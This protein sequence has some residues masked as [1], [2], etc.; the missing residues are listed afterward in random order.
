ML[1]TAPHHR[2]GDESS[3]CGCV[4]T[5]IVCIVLELSVVAYAQQPQPSIMWSPTGAELLEPLHW[6][7]SVNFDG[8]VVSVGGCLDERCVGISPT[9]TLFDVTTQTVATLPGEPPLTNVGITGPYTS[10]AAPSTAGASRSL[11]IVRSCSLCFDVDGVLRPSRNASSPQTSTSAQDFFREVVEV[12][13]NSSAEK[14]S[15]SRYKVIHN[16]SQYIPAAS[17]RCNASCVS[18][19]S[20]IYIVGGL[21]V[22]SQQE[23]NLIAALEL[24]TGAFRSEVVVIPST[25]FE[26]RDIDTL[27][28]SFLCSFGKSAPVGVASNNIGI[29]FSVPCWDP[30]SGMGATLVTGAVVYP[31]LSSILADTVMILFPNVS[32]P[33]G[34]DPI[35]TTTAILPFASQFMCTG[36]AVEVGIDFVFNDHVD[37]DPVVGDAAAVGQ[38]QYVGMSATVVAAHASFLGEL[39]LSPT[40]ATWNLYSLGGLH[41]DGSLSSDIQIGPTTFGISAPLEVVVS[42]AWSPSQGLH[43]NKTYGQGSFGDVRFQ[44]GSNL[45]IRM[46]SLSNA[47]LLMVSPFSDCA[48]PLD[49]TSIMTL[50]STFEVTIPITAPHANELFVCVSDGTHVLAGTVNATGM[51][52]LVKFFSAVN[53]LAPFEVLPIPPPTTLPPPTT[54][55]T[56][57]VPTT[58]TTAAPLPAPTTTTVAPQ[59]PPSP[60][61]ELPSWLPLYAV[62]IGGI[63]IVVIVIGTGITCVYCCRRYS[64]NERKQISQ[65]DLIALENIANSNKYT[66][67]RRLGS[68]GNGEVFLVKRKKDGEM[69]AIKHVRCV[70]SKTRDDLF[71][72]SDMLDR[73]KGHPNMVEIL[74]MSLHEVYIAEEDLDDD[75][76]G[77][78][79]DDEDVGTYNISEK[80]DLLTSGDHRGVVARGAARTS[81]RRKRAGSNGF[82]GYDTPSASDQGT[83]I[84][85]RIHDD[86]DAQYPHTAGGTTGGSD[87]DGANFLQV[88]RRKLRNRKKSRD[89]LNPGDDITVS[90]ASRPFLED[91]SDEPSKGGS[92]PSSD[93]YGKR[94]VI[95]SDDNTGGPPYA[96]NA[97]RPHTNSELSAS[98]YYLSTAGDGQTPH[99]T[100]ASGN[101]MRKVRFQCIVMKYFKKGDLA[102]FM[103]QQVPVFSSERPRNGSIFSSILRPKGGRTT[104]RDEIAS[105]LGSRAPSKAGADTTTTGG[106]G[107]YESDHTVASHAGLAAPDSCRTPTQVSDERLEAPPQPSGYSSDPDDRSSRGASDDDRNVAPAQEPQ[108]QPRV[109]RHGSVSNMSQASSSATHRISH[110]PGSTTAHSIGGGVAIGSLREEMI[111]SIVYQ[112]AALLRYLHSRKPNRIVHCDIKPE[113]ILVADTIHPLYLQLLGGQAASVMHASNQQNAARSPSRLF[114]RY[115]TRQSLPGFANPAPGAYGATTS[116]T[117]GLSVRPQSSQAS[118]RTLLRGESH[119][120]SSPYFV[121]QSQRSSAHAPNTP[122]ANGSLITPIGELVSSA[123]EDVFLPIVVSDVGQAMEVPWEDVK[124]P[125]MH[126]PATASSSSGATSAASP[127]AV[128]SSVTP[129]SNLRLQ[130]C[131]M[132]YV[133]PECISS[134]LR[135]VSPAIDIWALGCVVYSVCTKKLKHT[136]V[137]VMFEE[138]RKPSFEEDMRFELCEVLGYSPALATLVLA[139]LQPDPAKRPTAADITNHWMTFVPHMTQDVVPGVNKVQVCVPFQHPPTAPGGGG[140]GISPQTSATRRLIVQ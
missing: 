81:K 76:D 36:G 26:L 16:T 28:P 38:A 34:V 14:G 119:H 22:D 92:E 114:Q 109:R 56:T 43:D 83:A 62:I 98:S 10:V 5:L 42:A 134:G 19:G 86:S 95:M 24:S 4:A 108:R 25:L 104:S 44:T 29:F 35:T 17:S 59:A 57:A 87:V 77:D 11:F 111:A 6:T 106:G 60:G 123:L 88:R 1:T 90:T 131:T 21:L 15:P 3:T 67:I 84:N 41:G 91:E 125:P 55:T 94:R 103:E 137:V 115:L 50:V 47:D 64:E 63:A 53:L 116:P 52:H 126:P 99:S 132:P 70:G 12:A 20:V 68:G 65:R 117:N 9:V 97:S 121:G 82:I 61:L 40:G 18:L 27:S 7:S 54:T 33:S 129:S 8:N 113:N 75:D 102:T 58:T 73:L 124:L 66:V 37:G 89:T 105:Y 100:G 78:Y 85:S 13:V 79:Y 96:T 136:D 128:A 112:V 101:G 48:E 72:E 2:H 139:M 107:G 23:T 49:G 120:N 74:E 31:T 135:R 45:T 30:S 122:L 69:C 118:K 32:I 140:G 39:Q 127:P 110:G 80:T 51:P 130:Q 133:A 138:V 71:R 46:T 93:A